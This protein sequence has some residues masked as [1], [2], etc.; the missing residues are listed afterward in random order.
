MYPPPHPPTAHVYIYTHIYILFIIFPF[1]LNLFTMQTY[2]TWYFIKR[3]VFIR[4]YKRGHSKTAASENP[5]T[6]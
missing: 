4:T 3:C 2:F 1:I 6:S 5:H